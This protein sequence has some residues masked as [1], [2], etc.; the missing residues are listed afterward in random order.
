VPLDDLYHQQANPAFRFVVDVEGERQ[1]AFT[2]CSLPSVEWEVEELKEGG[3]NTYTHQLPGRRK[4]ARLSLKNGVGKSQLLQWYLD[5]VSAVVSR[6]PVTVTLLDLTH[7]PLM[8]WN[9]Q[10]AYPIK[11]TGPQ[12]KSDGNTIAIQTLELVCGEVTVSLENG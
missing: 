1:G 2:E 5:A 3:L 6:K 8:V 7:Q 10:D 12:L 4:S 11:W 9:I